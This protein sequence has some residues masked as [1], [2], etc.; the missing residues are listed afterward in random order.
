MCR[1][2]VRAAATKVGGYELSTVSGPVVRDLEKDIFVIL[3]RLLILFMLSI[4]DTKV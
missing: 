1:Q 3:C 2:S 4:Y